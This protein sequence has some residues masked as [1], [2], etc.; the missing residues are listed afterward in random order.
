MIPPTPTP[1]PPGMARFVMPESYSL[2]GSTDSAIQTW[3]WLGQSGQVIQLII[4]VGLVIAGMFVVYRFFRQF[5]ER[6]SGE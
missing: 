2:W 5:T 6:D 1:L 3:N 4:L